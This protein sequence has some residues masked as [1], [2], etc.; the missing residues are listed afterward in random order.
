MSTIHEHRPDPKPI[1]TEKKVK[2]PI[3]KVS[4][5]KKQ[6][7]KEYKKVRADYLTAHPVCQVD[8]CRRFASEIHHRAGR[9]GDLLCDASHFLAVCRTCHQKITINSAWAFE[10]GY[11][12]SRL[13]VNDKTIYK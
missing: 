7:L 4:E 3:A 6:G 11:S 12:E 5:K 2:K 13:S 10:K 9:A 8:G 1:K